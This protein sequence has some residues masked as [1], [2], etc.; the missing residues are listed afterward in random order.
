MIKRL[1]FIIK[2]KRK[3][4]ENNELFFFK[5][6]FFLLRIIVQLNKKE[7]ANKKA[8]LTFMLI[9]IF[10]SNFLIF[11]MRRR[12][13]LNFS[14]TADRRS[15]PHVD[16]PLEKRDIDIHK[17]ECI[18]FKHASSDAYF[19]RFVQDDMLHLFL[20]ILI[21]IKNVSHFYYI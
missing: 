12:L 20:R 7:R 1:F 8:K 15:S 18:N 11:Y 9:K 6:K 10:S 5:N 14:C 17:F 3:K 13:T 4:K 21:R 19:N 2:K 16:T